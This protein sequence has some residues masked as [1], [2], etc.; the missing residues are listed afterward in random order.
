MINSY[1]VELLLGLIE[2]ALLSSYQPS[3]E[4]ITTYMQIDK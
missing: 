3:F 1:N 4:I 2:P